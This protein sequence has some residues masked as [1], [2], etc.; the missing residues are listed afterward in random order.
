MVGI[1]HIYTYVIIVL[2]HSL[3]RWRA[4]SFGISAVNP[5]ESWI[6]RNGFRVYL[7]SSLSA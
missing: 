6:E 4:S 7:A 5:W 3:I 2:N 1:D